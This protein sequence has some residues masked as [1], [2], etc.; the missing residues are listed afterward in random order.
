V[1]LNA[2]ITGHT[3]KRIADNTGMGVANFSLRNRPH[4]D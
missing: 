2:A 1:R 3:A 4:R